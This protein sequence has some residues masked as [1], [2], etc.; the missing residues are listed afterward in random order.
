MRAIFAGLVC[1]AMAL[2]AQAEEQVLYESILGQGGLVCDSVEE[3]KSFIVAQEARSGDAPSGCGYLVRPVI[4]RVI[5]IG[6]FD[7]RTRT[8][9]LVRYEFLTVQM[10]H[11]YG[12][13][14]V[15]NNG[16]PA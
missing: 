14:A 9:L 16:E 10:P 13:M 11:Q 4:M 12:I 7:T 8:Y 3:V 6:T 15:R 1:L 5:G 2:P